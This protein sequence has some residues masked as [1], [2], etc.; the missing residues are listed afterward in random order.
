MANPQAGARKRP[1]KQ[2]I[3]AQPDNLIARIVVQ[4]GYL[5]NL[6]R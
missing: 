5:K 4:G 2:V 3:H 1:A 6:H